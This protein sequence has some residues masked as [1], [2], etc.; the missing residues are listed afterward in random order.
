MKR[1]LFVVGLLAVG[2]ADGGGLYHNT[3]IAEVA[4]FNVVTAGIA[5]IAGPGPAEGT[6]VYEGKGNI[7]ILIREYIINMELQGWMLKDRSLEVGKGT[8]M[9]VKG[10]R[11][12][13]IEF[14]SADGEEGAIGM[15]RASINV[16][17]SSSR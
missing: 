16:G 8:A 13:S 10:S 6:L 11:T 5:N 12:C 15:I 3:D 1:A 14:S 2:C 7:E 4:G 17:L 9:M